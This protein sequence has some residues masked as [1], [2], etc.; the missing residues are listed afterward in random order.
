MLFAASFN[1]T[2]VEVEGVRLSQ[3]AEST[4][5]VFDLSGPVEYSTLSLNNPSRFVLDIDGNPAMRANLQALPL[6]NTPIDKIRYGI[7]DT[8]QL[9]IVLDLNTEA[10]VQHFFLPRRGDAHDRLVVDLF[11]SRA[12]NTQPVMITDPSLE[13]RRDIIIAVDPGHGGNDPGAIGQKRV[14]EK[15]VVLDIGRRLAKLINA[16]PGYRAEMTRTG[17]ELIQLKRRRDI[18]RAMRADLFVSI[19]ADSVKQSSVRGASVYASNPNGRHATSEFARFLAQRENEADLIAG[20]SD[21]SLK[22]YQDEVVAGTLLDLIRTETLSASLEMGEHLL[23][24]LDDVARLHRR[25]VEEADFV[26]LRSP[27]VPSLLVESGFISNVDEEKRL[28]SSSYRQQLAEKI[29]DGIQSYF[30]SKPLPGTYI[31]WHKNNGDS[32]SEHVIA[33]GETLSGI[34][35]RYKVSVADIITANSLPNTRIRVGQHLKIPSI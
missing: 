18:A 2:A 31:A 5:V 26:V 33:R 16:Q 14:K 13:G 15:D 20:V 7:Q 11:S 3:T 12:V 22:D 21:I 25:S 28:N 19:H 23:D 6:A 4:R 10:E 8:K 24:S 32:F 27:D 1:A 29:F 34:A 17:D 9:R 35:L 30:Y